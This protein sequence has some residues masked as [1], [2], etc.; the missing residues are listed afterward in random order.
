MSE[1]LVFDI[2]PRY[3]ARTDDPPTSK[4]AAARVREFAGGHVGTILAC[5]QDFGPQTIDEI[6]KRTNL[7]AEQIARRLADMRPKSAEVP[8][9]K[10]LAE[11]TGATRNSASGRPERVWRALVSRTQGE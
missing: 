2:A 9:G 3:L 4:V 1:Q 10:S 5:L 11:P 6:A 7:T 8:H